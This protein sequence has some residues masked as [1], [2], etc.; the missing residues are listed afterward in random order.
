MRSLATAVTFA[1][2][3]ALPGCG[4]DPDWRAAQAQFSEAAAH[5]EQAG[6][7]LAD[8]TARKAE[9]WKASLGDSMET[10]KVSVADAKAHASVAAAASWTAV[11][12]KS[13][14]FQAKLVELE[15]AG[16]AASVELKEGVQAA[17]AELVVAVQEA[18]A[19]M[20]EDQH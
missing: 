8:L 10:L 11:E 13:E 12:A 14:T 18:K 7:H 3:V 20:K 4:D 6:G 16:S 17:Y 5:L 19:A 9:D 2:F 1:I 15:R